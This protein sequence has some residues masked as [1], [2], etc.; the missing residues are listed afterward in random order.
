MSW[1]LSVSLVVVL[2]TLRISGC[3]LGYSLCLWLLSWILSA[4]LIVV[5]VTL[6]VSGCC[7]GYSPCLWLLS[8]L[9]SLSLVAVLVT[10]F[11]SG[12]CLSYSPCFP[13]VVL[14]TLRVSE[15]Q[16]NTPFTLVLTTRILFLAEKDGG[17]TLSLR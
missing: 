9:L 4:S 13:V 15:P 3:C 14:V 16:S 7:L 10:F 12:C 1:L 17:S 5:L 11:V 6:H 2:V 8:W